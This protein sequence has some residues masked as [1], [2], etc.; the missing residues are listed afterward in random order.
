MKTSKKRITLTI[1]AHLV[2]AGN[3]AVSS[4][5][6]DSLS[7]WVNTALV[8]KVEEESR[9][10]ALGEAIALYEKEFGVITPQEMSAQERRD[11]E[12]ALVVR[13]SQK[14]RADSAQKRSAKGAA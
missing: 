8:H 1:D 6:A 12:R 4:G 14:R 13:G 7:A 5:E 2:D 10:M 11:K 3:K 9:L